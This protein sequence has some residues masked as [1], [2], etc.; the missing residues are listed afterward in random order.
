MVS[1][2]LMWFSQELNGVVT[3]INELLK[4]RSIK[5]QHANEFLLDQDDIQALGLGTNL[6]L[7]FTPKSFFL[8]NGMGFVSK[9]R[10]SV[11][12]GC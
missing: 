9:D 5:G 3:K 1:D 11:R 8:K 6:P 4:Q 7:L 2:S 10:F 12:S